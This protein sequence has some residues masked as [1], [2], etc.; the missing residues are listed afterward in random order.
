M[1]NRILEVTSGLKKQWKWCGYGHEYDAIRQECEDILSEIADTDSTA[2]VSVIQFVLKFYFGEHTMAPWVTTKS[3]QI[4]NFYLRKNSDFCD[5]TIEAVE[6]TLQEFRK[7]GLTSDVT[8]TGY[9]SASRIKIRDKLVGQSYTSLLDNRELFKKE[10]ITSFGYLNYLILRSQKIEQNWRY[11]LPLLLSFLEDSDML[12]KREAAIC[13]ISLLDRLNVGK[14]IVVA[15]QT[16]PLLTAAIQPILLAIPSLT[17]IDQSAII[18]P[19][20][21]EAT[22]KLYRIGIPESMDRYIKLSALLNDTLLPSL[23]KCKDYVPLMTVLI[24]ITHE[25]LQQ[26]EDFKMV[27]SKPIIYTVLTILMDP[28]V[29]HAVDIVN[30][31]VDIISDCL[32]SVENREKYK[33]DIDACLRVLRRRIEAVPEAT[34]MKFKAL[35]MMAGI[36]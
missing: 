20:A 1:D 16:L 34:D 27:V 32:E 33:Y 12:V 35:Q 4:A 17:P 3:R 28:Y 18:L 11:I 25:F 31:C 30:G 23:T 19:I 8:K 29:A 9:K 24:E 13:L 7:L 2:T 15:S 6:T 21:Y 36:D 10:F 14:N 5:I 26:C 22:F